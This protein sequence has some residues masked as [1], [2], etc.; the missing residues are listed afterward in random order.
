MA[1]VQ[2]GDKFFEVN[3]SPP[4]GVG[5]EVVWTFVQVLQ[6]AGWIG[7]QHGDGTS[8]TAGFP[9]SNPFVPG[10]TAWV[11]M[12]M[13]TGTWEMT[14][15]RGSGDDWSVRGYM[16]MGGFGSGGTAS[17]PPTAVDQVQIIGT[18]GAYDN[19]GWAWSSGSAANYRW[20]F[21][22]DSVPY[23]GFYY[24]HAIGRML[25]S[26]NTH[27]ILLLD[28]VESVADGTIGDA[29]AA[30]FFMFAKTQSTGGVNL[31]GYYKYGL[32]GEAWDENLLWSTP[33][34]FASRGQNPYTGVHQKAKL[35]VYRTAAQV[36]DK[37]RARNVRFFSGTLAV[38][39]TV[40]LAEVGAA[41]VHYNSGQLFPWPSGV[42]P[43]P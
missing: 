22:A 32:S 5:L 34:A 35:D 2:D 42:A 7:V 3:Y 41:Y 37:G 12:R 17:V 30:P 15:Q 43:S 20:S 18:G 14:L 11:Q 33:T 21:C 25:T 38:Y 23:R 31:S 10:T 24:F 29:D 27:R 40:D 4:A 6:A 16:S 39:D 26:G 1:I 28:P 13:P 9:A 8:K 19:G 36:Q